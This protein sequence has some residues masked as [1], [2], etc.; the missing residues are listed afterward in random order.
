MP[1][2]THGKF[3][4][5]ITFG[6]G[7]SDGAQGAPTASSPRQEGKPQKNP[8]DG[9]NKINAAMVAGVQVTMQLGRQALDASV[10]NIGIATGN[11]YAQAQTQRVLSAGSGIV[12]LV[13]A[14]KNPVTLALSVGAMAISA[15]AEIR[16][17]NIERN[18]ANYT[19]EQY[20]K[21]LGY[22]IDRR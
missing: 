18:I 13:L 16:R 12:G 9:D 11:Y 22:S 2:P 3:D 17:Q 10:S 1:I 6:D 5:Y 7:E 14:A 19:A 20:A 21:R 4:I 8:K 15:G